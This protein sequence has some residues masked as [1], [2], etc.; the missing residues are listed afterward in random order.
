MLVYQRVS[1]YL[2]SFS[3]VEIPY[4]CTRFFSTKK[5]HRFL[6]AKHR[7]NSSVEKVERISSWQSKF[8]VFSAAKPTFES[9]AKRCERRTSFRW[10]SGWGALLR[11]SIPLWGLSRHGNGR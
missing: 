5:R 1:T 8:Q 11:F 3:M 6:E 10:V 7:W 2:R 4:G 9:A